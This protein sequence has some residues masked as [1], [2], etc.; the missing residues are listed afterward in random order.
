MK[1]HHI[2]KERFQYSVEYYV[3]G[4]T[5]ILQENG[6]SANEEGIDVEIK[7]SI[8]LIFE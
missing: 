2:S 8:D 5:A 6:V 3:S 4:N 1:E 7:K